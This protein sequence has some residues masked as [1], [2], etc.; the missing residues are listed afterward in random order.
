M[1]TLDLGVI[2]QNLPFLMEGLALSL[3]LTALA[4]IGKAVEG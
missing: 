2:A 1:D 4:V 3:E